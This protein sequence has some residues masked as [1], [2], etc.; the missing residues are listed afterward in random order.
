MNTQ[1]NKLHRLAL[2]TLLLL[3]WAGTS[4]LESDKDQILVYSNDGNSKT[5]IEGDVR[6]YEMVNNVKV[7][8]GTLELSG[9]EAIFEY[10]ANTGELIRVTVHG[11]PAEYQQQLDTDEGTIIGSSDTILFYTDEIDGEAIVE[12]FGN[13][14]I[15]SPDSSMNC[16]EMIVYNIDQNLINTTGRCDGVFNAPQ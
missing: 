4:A 12:L 10:D 14:K 13:A 3:S 11:S 1:L 9:D 2:F 7:T 16:V 5:R 15:R 8:Q 6:I